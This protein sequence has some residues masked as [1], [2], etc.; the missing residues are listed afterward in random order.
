M[1]T[2]HATRRTTDAGRPR[3][4]L[5]DR[6]WLLIGAVVFFL[7]IVVAVVVLQALV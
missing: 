7:E 1:T 3:R 2:D 5:S 4:R 6:H